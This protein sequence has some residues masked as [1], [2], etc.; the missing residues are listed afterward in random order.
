MQDIIKYKELNRCK[1]ITQRFQVETKVTLN[2]KTSFRA[3]FFMF[4]C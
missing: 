4:Y 3:G 1:D 2:S